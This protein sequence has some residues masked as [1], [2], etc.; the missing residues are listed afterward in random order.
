MR[1][2]TV[3]LLP[4]PGGPWM[5]LRPPLSFRTALSW[6]ALMGIWLWAEQPEE[7]S[8]SSDEGVRTTRTR[9]LADNQEAVG[10]LS[11]AL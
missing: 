10:Q 11:T 9:L 3:V 5:A 7:E 2:K 1:W 8:C 6:L 4:V